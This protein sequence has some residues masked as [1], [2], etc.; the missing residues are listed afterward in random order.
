MSDVMVEARR[1]PRRLADLALLAVAAA[2]GLTFP[3]G[4]IVLST[5][6]PFTYLAVRFGLAAA[7]LLAILPRGGAATSRR[8][9]TAA[10]GVGIVLFVAYG[11]Q[12]FGLRLT[13][14]SNAGLITGLSVAMVPVISAVWLRRMPHP[15]V[16]AGV[17]AA[18][19][20]LGLLTRSR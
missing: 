13:T 18:T 5:L 17:A 16:L 19:I 3:L 2:W 14:A 6:P 11:L 15:A 1:V 20:G 10:A 9:W 7:V 12:T 8:D 4:K